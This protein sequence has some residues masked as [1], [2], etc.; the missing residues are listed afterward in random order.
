MISFR[1]FTEWHP[2]KLQREYCVV[3]YDS[4]SLIITLPH[5]HTNHF[6]SLC[7]DE[8][9]AEYRSKSSSN[10]QTTAEHEAKDTILRQDIQDC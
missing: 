3:L 2:S 1:G 5:F 9:S 6:S 10:F 7:L 8:Q 4:V